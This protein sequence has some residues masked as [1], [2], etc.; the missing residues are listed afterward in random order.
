M[1]LK[2]L[3]EISHGAI[4]SDSLFL[5]DEVQVSQVFHVGDIGCIY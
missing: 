1:R 5:K 2:F 4:L 3:K